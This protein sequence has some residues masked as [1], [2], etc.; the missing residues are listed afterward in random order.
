LAGLARD[1]SAL[2]VV[3]KMKYLLL[4]VGLCAG[5]LPVNSK[6]IHERFQIKIGGIQQW[7]KIDSDEETK[8]VLL[9][10]HGGPGNSVIPYAHKFTNELQQHFVVVLWDQRES[11]ETKKLN[12]SP[13]PLIVSLFESDAVEVIDYLRT[14]FRQDKIY[15]AGHS[16]GGFLALQVASH[17]GDRLEACFAAAPMIRQ[18]ESEQ[19]SLQKEKDIA[20]KQNNLTAL[21][22]LNKIQ[23]PFKTGEQ[24]YFHRKWLN[25]LIDQRRAPFTRNYVEGWARTWLP[26]FNEASAIDLNISAKEM[27]CPT[28]LLVGAKDYQTNFEITKRYFENLKAPKKELFWFNESSHLLNLTEPKKF[29]QVIIST[30]TK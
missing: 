5:G 20:T 11:G 25:E 24:L 29:Q 30:L 7:I 26:I 4:L 17:Y 28:F 1:V 27:K 19:L 15:L 14:R 2:F 6:P 13:V 8:P 23:I 16:W 9:F 18:T 22:E 10:L 12:S 3:D 21:E